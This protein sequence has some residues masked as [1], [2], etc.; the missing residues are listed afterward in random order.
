[1]QQEL[2]SLQANGGLAAPRAFVEVDEF[3]ALFETPAWRRPIFLI[4][5]AT[6]LGK[7]L[8][9]A[10]ILE[11]V[12]TA[13]RLPSFSFLEVTVEGDG[14]LDLSDFD[15]SKHSGVLFDGVSDV[16]LL[17]QN[18][19]TLQGRPKVLKGG[20][21][22]TMRYAYP[23]TLA[24]RAVV[25]TMDLSAANLDL[26]RTDHWLSDA[27]NVRVLRLI[28]PAWQGGSLVG[29][30]ML[31]SRREKIATWTAVEVKEA[32]RAKDLEGPSNVLFHNGVRGQDFLELTC[33]VMQSDL[34]MSKLASTNVMRA[35]A[36]CLSDSS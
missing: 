14:H 9:A 31:L 32:L 21:S 12:A 8:L 1:M 16:L 26:L 29:G 10:S 7:S 18:R 4:V 25:A 36:A 23:F 20:R 6:N 11:R 33:D 24:R 5:G 13:L 17:K 27:R 34:R 35:R 19:E 22:Q 30:G 15:A 2:H 28:Q 3:V